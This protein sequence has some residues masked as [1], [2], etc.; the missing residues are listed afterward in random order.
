[1]LLQFWASWCHSCGAIMFDLDELAQKHPGINYIAVSLDDEEA[2]A[3][4]Y[5][6]KHK[7]YAKNPERYFLDQ[8]K[9]LATSLG[10]KT[11]PTIILLT[12]EGIELVRKS[13]HL[14]SRDLQQL[15]AGMQRNKSDLPRERQ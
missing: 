5:I 2:S 11:V 3:R 9:V 10:V 1:M 14:N 6:E 8:D 15:A 4:Q 12:A 7:L 13:G